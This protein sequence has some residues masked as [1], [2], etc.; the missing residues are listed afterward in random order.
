YH[1]QPGWWPRWEG[2]SERVK[3]ILAA[4]VVTA[5][6][7]IAR[8]QNPFLVTPTVIDGAHSGDCTA[9]PDIDLDATSDPIVTSS[10]TIWY[11][12][13]AGSA[14]HTIRSQPVYKEF[15]TD[16]QAADIDNDGDPD[17]IVGDGRG[18]QNL[19]WFE[20]PRINGP[21]GPVGDPRIGADWIVHVIGTQGD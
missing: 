13:P 20:N 9:L 19:I 21:H 8:A 16:M 7:V 11:E 18:Q 4:L 10:A 14:A 2:G 12:A 1:C 17:I 15:T 6:P 5:L 3:I